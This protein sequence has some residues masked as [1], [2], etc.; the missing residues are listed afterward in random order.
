VRPCG[1]IKVDQRCI[2]LC[3]VVYVLLRRMS[4]EDVSFRTIQTTSNDP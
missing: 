1:D 2:R 4:R 3:R